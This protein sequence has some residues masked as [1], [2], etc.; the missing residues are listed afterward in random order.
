MKMLLGALR[1]EEEKNNKKLSVERGRDLIVLPLFCR[2]KK[3]GVYE[4]KH[5]L[6]SSLGKKH[7]ETKL[8]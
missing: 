2:Q 6:R 1:C 5:V 3:P 7:Y 8:V 4:M